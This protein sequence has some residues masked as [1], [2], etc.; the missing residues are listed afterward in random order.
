M[1]NNSIFPHRTKPLT[2][3]LLKAN[4]FKTNRTCC[5]NW[6]GASKAFSFCW[7]SCS[8]SFNHHSLNIMATLWSSP[9]SSG[10][11]R[12]FFIRCSVFIWPAGWKPWMQIIHVS[13][14]NMFCL[15]PSGLKPVSSAEP[16]VSHTVYLPFDLCTHYTAALLFLSFIKSISQTSNWL[17]IF[18]S[19]NNLQIL[20]NSFFFFLYKDHSYLLYF[21]LLHTHDAPTW[22]PLLNIILLHIISLSRGVCSS[23]AKTIDFFSPAK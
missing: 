4:S 22:F 13:P 5:P 10:W 14:F 18:S 19:S 16:A 2:V 6:T 1:G 3:V 8:F 20:I 21:A 7:Q 15:V 9:T 17:N 11:E 12:H 23:D